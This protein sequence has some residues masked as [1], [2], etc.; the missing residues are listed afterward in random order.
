MHLS[1]QNSQIPS[2]ALARQ[3]QSASLR[4]AMKAPPGPKYGFITSRQAL[5]NHLFLITTPQ[6][7]VQVPSV[8]TLSRLRWL[9]DITSGVPKAGRQI[10][11]EL[12]HRGPLRTVRFLLT[13]QGRLILWRRLNLARGITVHP[14]AIRFPTVFNFAG[15]TIRWRQTTRYTQLTQLIQLQT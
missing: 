3:I 7:I 2:Q 14:A 9:L 8:H 5:H 12:I 15:K 10:T 13:Y 11:A 1:R 6:S 4:M